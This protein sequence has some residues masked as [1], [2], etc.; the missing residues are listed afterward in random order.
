VA[1]MLSND[2]IDRLLAI[3]E[4]LRAELL[5]QGR[6]PTDE[7]PGD[8]DPGDGELAGGLLA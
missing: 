3:G 8:D 1:D 4:Q 2:E 5:G 7:K 6:A